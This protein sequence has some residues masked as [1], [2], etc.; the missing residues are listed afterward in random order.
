MASGILGSADVGAT[1]NTTVYTVPAATTAAVNVNICNRT[2][3]AIAVRIAL[4]STGTPT[5][6]E[7]IEYDVSIPANGVLERTGLVMDAAKN[8]VVYAGAAGISAVAVGFEE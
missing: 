6:A 7:Y 8:L 5:L 1:T 4:S 2:A 3:A